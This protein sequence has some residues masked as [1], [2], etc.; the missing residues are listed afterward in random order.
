MKVTVENQGLET[1]VW[2]EG[3][4]DT[5]S[6]LEVSKQLEEEISAKE[7]SRTV[8][9][10]CTKLDYISSSGLRIFLTLR[11]AASAAGGKVVIRNM[12]DNIRSVFLITGFLNLFEVF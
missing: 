5:P 3:R 6:S 7:A 12:N 11:K 10:D 8:I 9:L 2:F 1:I 4:L